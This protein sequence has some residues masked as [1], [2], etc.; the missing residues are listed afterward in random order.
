MALQPPKTSQN[1]CGGLV[2]EFPSPEIAGG[3]LTFPDGVPKPLLSDIY[4]S[5]HSMRWGEEYARK[6]TVMPADILLGDPADLCEGHSGEQ[7][8]TVASFCIAVFAC[9]INN[10]CAC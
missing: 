10:L 8:A 5:F 2:I 4:K 7:F 3:G 9:V 6:R 1:I